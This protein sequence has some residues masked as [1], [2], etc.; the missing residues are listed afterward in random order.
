MRVS[1]CWEHSAHKDGFSA[2]GVWQSAM[3]VHGAFLWIDTGWGLRF[4]AGVDWPK[5]CGFVLAKSM[6]FIKASSE[7]ESVKYFYPGN[8]IYCC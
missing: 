4:Q 5:L 2:D 8:D 3:E 6:Q 1:H 7:T